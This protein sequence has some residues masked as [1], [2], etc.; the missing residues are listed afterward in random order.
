MKQNNLRLRGLQL[1]CFQ[2]LHLI[3]YYS[4]TPSCF[5]SLLHYQLRHGARPAGN[6]PSQIIYYFITALFHHS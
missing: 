1:L 6:I 5:F 2:L 4:I 3:F